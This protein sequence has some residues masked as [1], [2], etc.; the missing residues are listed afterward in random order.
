MTKNMK[1]AIMK[2][3]NPKVGNMMME[4]KGGKTEMKEKIKG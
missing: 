1:M 2:M 4:M 3:R